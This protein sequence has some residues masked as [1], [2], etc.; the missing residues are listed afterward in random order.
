MD[1]DI[2]LTLSSCLRR[3]PFLLGISED[4][5]SFVLV[6][7]KERHLFLPHGVPSKAEHHVV[8]GQ[9]LVLALVPFKSPHTA[10][11]LVFFP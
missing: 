5:G 7:C 3:K 11:F 6:L 8:L 9:E 2:S 4:L 1:F 10:G